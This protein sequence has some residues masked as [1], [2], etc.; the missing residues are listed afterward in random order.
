VNKA[1]GVDREKI[2][3]NIENA[4]LDGLSGGL[5]FTPDNHSGLLPDALAVLVVRQGQWHLAG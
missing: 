3:D 1:G 2:R 5:R 4:Q